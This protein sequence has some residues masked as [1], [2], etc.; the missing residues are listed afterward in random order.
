MS[1]VKQ[2]HR[3]LL[4]TGTTWTQELVWLLQND[5]DFEGAKSM[6]MPDRYHFLEI[7]GVTARS[8]RQK[9]REEEQSSLS[10][11]IFY[12]PIESRP[13]PWF[14]KT[15]QPLHMCPPKLLDTAKVAGRHLS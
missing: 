6:L 1:I 13:L 4:S 14:V 9:I 2:Q 5:C 10:Y 12:E 11:R 8:V 7:T 15:H 3:L